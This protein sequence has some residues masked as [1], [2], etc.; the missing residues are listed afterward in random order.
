[1]STVAK[2]ELACDIRAS[3]ASVS[4]EAIGGIQFS[5]TVTFRDA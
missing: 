5:V 2:E 1:M 4:R 3:I